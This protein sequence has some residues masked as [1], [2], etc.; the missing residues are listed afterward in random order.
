MKALFFSLL[1]LCFGSIAIGQEM[2]TDEEWSA[3]AE[4]SLR[5]AGEKYPAALVEDS[6]MRQRMNRIDEEWGAAGDPRYDDPKKAELLAEHVMAAYQAVYNRAAEAM[7]AHFDT[8]SNREL[9]GID[10]EAHRSW[11]EGLIDSPYLTTAEH[12]ML[13]ESLVLDAADWKKV[14]RKMVEKSKI[15]RDEA[16]I[17][18]LRAE[19]ARLAAEAKPIPGGVMSLGDQSRYR[20]TY[21][22]PTTT[23]SKP[24][25]ITRSGTISSPSGSSTY[26]IDRRGG[27]TIYGRDGATFVD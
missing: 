26:S 27:I 6:P 17:L 11:L 23:R 16:E 3:A 20:V 18:A 7:E 1:F 4:A 2:L 15:Q 24:S 22:L 14:A 8:L 12:A 25:P 21:G 10:L 13:T 19:N 9:A 5:R